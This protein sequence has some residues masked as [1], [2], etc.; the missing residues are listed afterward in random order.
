MTII[1]SV[2]M[3]VI[4][5]YSPRPCGYGINCI[6]L[7]EPQ[8]ILNSK[9]YLASGVHVSLF[10]QFRVGPWKLYQGATEV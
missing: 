4:M 7:L 10:T 2:K 8:N 1:S 3:S 5:G 6:I 9:I